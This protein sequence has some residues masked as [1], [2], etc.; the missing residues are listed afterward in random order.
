L[1]TPPFDEF[2]E[3]KWSDLWLLYANTIRFASAM[4][5]GGD[6]GVFAQG[7]YYM[8]RSVQELHDYLKLRRETKKDNTR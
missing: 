5:G 7:R 1:K 4:A 6:Y 8:S 2:I 3:K